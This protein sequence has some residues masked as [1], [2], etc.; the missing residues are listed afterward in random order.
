VIGAK[1]L[2]G[3]VSFGDVRVGESTKEVIEVRDLAPTS[4]RIISASA[5]DIERISV[6]VLKAGLEPERTVDGTQCI[7]RVEITT[8]SD[9]PGSL[10]DVLVIMLDGGKNQRLEAPI[11]AR[12]VLP[13]TAS[14]SE[15]VLPLRSTNGPLYS[16]M[17]VIRG[18][19]DG[20]LFLTVAKC[21]SD[22]LVELQQVKANERAR[23][24]KITLANKSAIRTTSSVRQVLL[25]GQQGGAIH[26]VAIK[27]ILR[28]E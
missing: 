16:A 13:I 21:P 17:C 12:F 26:D 25:R 3:V 22:L 9:Q 4:H 15:L 20:P 28:E 24:I 27:V 8:K 6:R 14:P 10:D 5:S 1:L 11:R 19:L 23:L 2:P 18:E 7:A